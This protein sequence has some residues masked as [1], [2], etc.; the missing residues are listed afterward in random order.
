MKRHQNLDPTQNNSDEATVAPRRMSTGKRIG[1]AAA[2][3]SLVSGGVAAGA[4]YNIHEQAVAKANA[5]KAATT[6]T[7][8]Y[9]KALVGKLKSAYVGPV[10]IT[11]AENTGRTEIDPT[12]PMGKRGVVSIYI[13][14]SAIN[15]KTAKSTG[16][17]DYI[18]STD[19]VDHLV[20]PNGEKIPAKAHWVSTQARGDVV[21]NPVLSNFDGSKPKTFNY[22]IDLTAGGTMPNGQEVDA[23]YDAGDIAVTG[24]H[25][26]ITSVAVVPRPE[27]VPAVQIVE[28]RNG[29]SYLNMF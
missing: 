17:P 13:G 29:E 4:A 2:F 5:A 24:S 25:G 11:N 23:I 6:K 16:G 7:A 21:A 22:E 27:D 28:P 12:D 8:D 10:A 1:A 26:K 15:E 9:R 3:V 18:Y 19:P 20:L 14:G